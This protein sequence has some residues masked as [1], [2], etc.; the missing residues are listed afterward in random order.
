MSD[1]E[2]GTCAAWRAAFVA[3][4]EWISDGFFLAFVECFE[5]YRGRRFSMGVGYVAK[6]TFTLLTLHASHALLSRLCFWLT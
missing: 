1:F 6:L 3:L 5:G 2:G 4:G